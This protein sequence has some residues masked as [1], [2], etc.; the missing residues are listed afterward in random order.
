[1]PVALETMRQ[2][3]FLFFG[4][5]ASYAFATPSTNLVNDVVE[6]AETDHRQVGTVDHG[7]AEQQHP[8]AV[9]DN[10]SVKQTCAVCEGITQMV[11]TPLE[12]PFRATIAIL[13]N[14]REAS[15]QVHAPLRQHSE[16]YS[17][18][19]EPE[20]PESVYLGKEAGDPR[21]IIYFERSG[22]GPYF[23]LLEKPDSQRSSS[24]VRSVKLLDPEW[25]DLEI[26]KA[27]VRVCEKE[28]GETCAS[29]PFASGYD[30][31]RPAYLIDALEGRLVD[32][33][34]I[35]GE[36]LR[37]VALSHPQ[38][39]PGN[40][41]DESDQNDQR[42][43]VTTTAN[44]AQLQEPGVLLSPTFATNMTA[45]FRDVIELVRLLEYRYIWIPP[46]CIV[47]DD[48][49]NR[50]AE[51]A[52]VADI[53]VGAVFSINQPYELK[54]MQ[55]LRGIRELKNPQP[56]NLVQSL[57]PWGEE[58]LVVSVGQRVADCQR[59]AKTQGTR[60]VRASALGLQEAFLPHRQLRFGHGSVEWR[61]RSCSA[62]EDTAR[63]CDKNCH[64][65][66]SP[67]SVLLD[68]SVLEGQNERYRAPWTDALSLPWF[69]IDHYFQALN[70]LTELDSSAAGE[71][72]DVAAGVISRLATHSQGSLLCGMP[73]ERLDIALLFSV[74]S[75]GAPGDHGARRREVGPPLQPDLPWPSWSWV[76]WT[77]PVLID[78]TMRGTD[79]I[80]PDSQ[81]DIIPIVE[82]YASD[83]PSP[84]APRRRLETRLWDDAK[85]RFQHNDLEPVPAGW[86]RQL[87]DSWDIYPSPESRNQ[88]RPGF[89][90]RVMYT[91]KSLPGFRF[92]YP[93]PIRS[94][95]GEPTTSTS[96]T[97]MTTERFLSGVVNRVFLY[98]HSSDYISWYL[99]QPLP[100]Y[101]EM[102]QHVGVLQS[103][104]DDDLIRL[105]GLPTSGLG[106]FPPFSFE[107]NRTEDAFVE[108]AE[109]RVEVI[110]LSKMYA[111]WVS[112][113]PEFRSD[114]I[115][116]YHSDYYYEFYNVMW[117]EWT[118]G[119]AYRKGIGRV[120]TEFWEQLQSK[121]IDLILG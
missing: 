61:C 11:G 99:N 88:G 34:S 70:Q 63:F 77:G 21:L 106:R 39:S 117:I 8:I 66:R 35:T 119:V 112:N 76:G 57:H 65:L 28:H 1:M 97:R 90:N 10:A 50:A 75:F 111:R 72:L 95:A 20:K 47:Q 59:R 91:H 116:R 38:Q 55:G 105:L 18:S 49:S 74:S 73:E 29:S 13:P 94:A 69:S 19:Q 67:D 109:A 92:A 83:S 45:M 40:Q 110:A 81:V 33:S 46:L 85:Q 58:T 27:W 62:W 79:Y 30:L 68:P 51:T 25:I 53:L 26:V 64:S 54:T 101:S 17:Y 107:A 6:L 5:C 15:C 23:D 4:L 80:E 113:L 56:R 87:L 93:I 48:P 100:V 52:K 84:D 78:P 41:S 22:Q 3:W 108:K 9:A 115:T 89:D 2:Y 121:S 43:L 120:L 98:I 82:W 102:G 96:R 24:S 114:G 60:G 118:D 103:T 12:E 71:T 104:G 32:T 86:A 37:Y 36:S 14:S 44:L 31:Q 16:Q 7:Q 42:Y